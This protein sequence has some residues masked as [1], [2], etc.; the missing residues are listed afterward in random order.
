MEDRGDMRAVCTFNTRVYQAKRR[1][2]H[3][4][5]FY[6]VEQTSRD[7]TI[8]FKTM[9]ESSWPRRQTISQLGSQ[10][11]HPIPST[12]PNVVI[13]ACLWTLTVN[14]CET[15][16]A[17]ITSENHGPLFVPIQ[18]LGFYGVQTGK[19]ISQ[20]HLIRNTTSS[21]FQVQVFS[22][23]VCTS[24]KTHAGPPAY[25]T[26]WRKAITLALMTPTRDSY[27]SIPR[28]FSVWLHSGSTQMPVP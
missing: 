13:W 17:I 24:E 26:G 10:P 1:H 15:K 19:K 7:S 14:M 4:M 3:N 20:V 18:D 22:I 8:G 12:K 9:L 25:K 23:L 16:Q 2:L 11:N 6:L 28:S 5:T 27:F 21:L